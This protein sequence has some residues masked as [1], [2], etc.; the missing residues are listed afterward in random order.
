MATGETK[1]ITGSLILEDRYQTTIYDDILTISSNNKLFCNRNSV[2]F[3]EYYLDVGW[4]HEVDSVS[5]LREMDVIISSR[6][7]MF[8]K[9]LSNGIVIVYDTTSGVHDAKTNSRSTNWTEAQLRREGYRF[10]HVYSEIKF[11]ATQHWEQC[12]SCGGVSAKL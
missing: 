6:H 8:Y 11:K 7:A 9:E 2:V 4:G 5:E 12:E 3:K 1:R 10:Y